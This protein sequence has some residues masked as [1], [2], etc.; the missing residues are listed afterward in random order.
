MRI[1]ARTNVTQVNNRA[2]I[3]MAL[4]LNYAQTANEKETVERIIQNLEEA[5]IQATEITNS[6]DNI[7]IGYSVFI[8]MNNE[9]EAL[10]SRFLAEL[11]Q[12]VN[13]A[14]P[15]PPTLAALEQ[16]IEELERDDRIS[17]NINLV[18][19][20]QLDEEEEAVGLGRE[21]RPQ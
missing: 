20:M 1:T 13:G 16:Q 5:G 18:E 15:L 3:D 10:Y 17:M 12:F 2:Q 19:S 21:T 7:I 11:K 6:V 9:Q 8:P 14:N 4:D